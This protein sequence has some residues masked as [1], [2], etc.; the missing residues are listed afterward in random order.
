MQFTTDATPLVTHENICDS[1]A[2]FHS[3]YI[4]NTLKKMTEPSWEDL[5]KIIDKHRNKNKTINWTE[6]MEN[7]VIKGSNLSRNA[8]EYR[9]KKNRT[10]VSSGTST[11]LEPSGDTMPTLDSQTLVPNMS[12]S[13]LVDSARV[14]TP[15]L[16]SSFGDLSISGGTEKSETEKLSGSLAG[17]TIFRTKNKAVLAFQVLYGLEVVN[18]V[19]H[20]D[21]VIVSWSLYDKGLYSDSYALQEQIRLVKNRYGEI[22]SCDPKESKCT[23][24][25]SYQI[26]E[27]TYST[28]P[29]TKSWKEGGHYFVEIVAIDK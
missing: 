7:D 9:I 6:L 11:L 5:S 1:L 24:D 19:K 12:Q 27:P 10:Q 20:D 29:I 13:S 18:V 16:S 28:G 23:V 22:L 8:I 26:G 21:T 4:R 14:D 17:L 15:V 2:I 25:V 3:Q